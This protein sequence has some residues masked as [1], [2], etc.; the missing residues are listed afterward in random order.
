MSPIK[1]YYSYPKD[2][3]Q[4]TDLSLASLVE[5][6]RRKK[7]LT[8]S[9]GNVNVVSF[10]PGGG[11][12]INEI[13]CNGGIVVPF[14]DINPFY[15]I[16]PNGIH[17]ERIL[18]S[19]DVAK[20]KYSPEEKKLST[21]IGGKNVEILSSSTGENGKIPADLSVP[22][23]ALCFLDQSVLKETLEEGLLVGEY[24]PKHGEKTVIAYFLLLPVNKAKSLGISIP[25]AKDGQFI[26]VSF[27]PG[28]L[29]SH[30]D[31]DSSN[32]TPSIN[33]QVLEKA[34][35]LKPVVAC[36]FNIN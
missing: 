18:C 33:I 19:L 21:V 14:S 29:N 34:K 25:N 10:L 30:Y 12:A 23:S 2:T 27:N 9:S 16:F 35:E 5:T 7:I 22:F 24:Y 13:G 11:K 36:W 1:E 6:K 17:S 28:I 4:L 8:F 32:I 31:I 20:A 15:C 3:N 26:T